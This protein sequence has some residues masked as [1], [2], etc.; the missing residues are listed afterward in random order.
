MELIETMYKLLQGRVLYISI[1]K[2][3]V[4]IRIYYRVQVIVKKQGNLLALW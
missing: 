2:A 4:S 1:E 3:L